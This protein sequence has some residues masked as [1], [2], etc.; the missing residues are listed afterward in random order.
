M[1]EWCSD[2]HLSKVKNWQRWDENSD[3][4]QSMC[5]GG[6]GGIAHEQTT[7]FWFCFEFS[8]TSYI[9]MMNKDWHMCSN[10]CENTVYSSTTIWELILQLQYVKGARKIVNSLNR[11]GRCLFMHTSFETHLKWYRETGI[12][13]VGKD[14]GGQV[15]KPPLFPFTDITKSL[16]SKQKENI[17]YI[18]D[19]NVNTERVLLNELRNEATSMNKCTTSSVSRKIGQTTIRKYM[20]VSLS[21][22]PEMSSGFRYQSGR[23][24]IMPENRLH[25]QRGMLQ[26]W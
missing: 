20:A 13:P 1:K 8:H 10:P 14:L 18:E 4:Q 5:V 15:G 23:K 19:D 2:G 25:V 17:G 24:K 21:L 6:V 26:V 7:N 3:Q 9:P 11:Q 12:L 22:D 16:N